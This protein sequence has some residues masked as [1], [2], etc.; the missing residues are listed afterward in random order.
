MNKA[1]ARAL[2]SAKA[3]GLCIGGNMAQK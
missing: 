1:E 2:L 3:Q